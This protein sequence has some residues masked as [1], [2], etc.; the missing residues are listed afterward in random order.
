MEEKHMQAER[1]PE[2]AKPEKKNRLPGPGGKKKYKRLISVTVV[3]LAAVL[4][5]SWLLRGS[6]VWKLK[7][8]TAPQAVPYETEPVQQRDLGVT[9]TGSA[10]LE[11]ADAYQVGTLVSG[12]ILSAPFEE[13][14]QVEK[15]TL[16]YTLDSGSAQDSVA[17][18]N[19]SV[20]QARLSYQQALEAQT[21]TA[22]ISG[23]LNEVYVHDGDSVS[24]GTALAKI[25]A[26]TDLTIDFLFTYASPDQ[27]YAGQPATVFIGNFDGTVQGTVVSVSDNTSVTANGKQSCTVR[28]KLPNPGIVSDSFTASAVIGSYTSYGNAPIS[29]AASAVVYASGSGTVSGF[30][31][32]AGSTVT[33]GEQLCTVDS[34]S[35]RSQLATAKLTVESAQLSAGTAAS[36][37]DDYTIRSPIAGTVIEK[38]C[39]AGDKV[40]GASSGTLAVIYDLSYLK[41]EMNVNE[42]DI[43]KVRPGQIVEITAAALPGQAF[44]GTVER[45]SVNGT[46]TSGFTTYP[47]TIVLEEYGDLKPGMNVSATILGDTAKHVLAVPVAAVN[48]GNTVLVAGA[49]ALGEDGTTVVDLSKAEERPVTLGRSDAEYIEITEGLT[50][51]DTVLVPAQPAETEG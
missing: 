13:D 3:L 38:N 22:P 15:D 49:G 47:V 41:M 44:T 34:E 21:P 31:K 46:T 50:A 28:V 30:S 23:I 26:S 48:R 7:S 10:T 35:I 4:L 36:A 25:V 42:L 14:Q 19:I 6:Q 18:A 9:V 51:G 43:G 12:T 1:L 8:G 11:P 40:D 32:L 24:A 29:M 37:V 33:K 45:V 2:A 16:L 39:K 20:E 27:F 17:R 5:G